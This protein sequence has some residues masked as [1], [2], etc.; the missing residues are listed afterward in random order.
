MIRVLCVSLLTL[1]S[2]SISGIYKNLTGYFLTAV[3]QKYYIIFNL[4]IS[5]LVNYNG[6]ISVRVFSLNISLIFI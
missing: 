4:N 3:A 1:Q 6:S 5:I 2:L